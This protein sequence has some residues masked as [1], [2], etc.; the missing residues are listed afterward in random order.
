MCFFHFFPIKS[1]KKCQKITIFSS[2]PEDF[3]HVF[4]PKSCEKRGASPARRRRRNSVPESL[5]TCFVAR[6]DGKKPGI[7]GKPGEK[8]GKI[9]GK[10]WKM[11]NILK[12]G[13]V[14]LGKTWKTSNIYGGLL[15]KSS[16]IGEVLMG[17]SSI[18]GRAGKNHQTEWKHGDNSGKNTVFF[19][20]WDISWDYDGR[21]CENGIRIMRNKVGKNTL[22]CL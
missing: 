14:L 12:N 22:F 3:S 2:F 8:P 21:I 9:Q 18:G 10:W 17:L 5:T 7:W 16:R 1:L 20:L 4:H 13:V 6:E 15:G 11:W 19:I